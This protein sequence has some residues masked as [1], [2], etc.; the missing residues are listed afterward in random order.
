M[1]LEDF[2]PK[3]NIIKEGK[4][5]ELDQDLKDKKMSDADFKKKYNKSKADVRKEIKPKKKVAEATGDARF[6]KMMGNITG[7]DT[8]SAI[9]AQ[10]SGQIDRQIME[11]THKIFLRL[12][13]FDDPRVYQKFIEFMVKTINNDAGPLDEERHIQPARKGPA[14]DF[15][16]SFDYVKQCI[17]NASIN[18]PPYNTSE[19]RID[20]INEAIRRLELLKS[21]LM[22]DSAI[23]NASRK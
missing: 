15:N 17:T 22:A 23:G 14:V 21:L 12:R 20:R 9:P 19:F 16:K 3:K 2:S 18:V 6:D 5:K 7:S 13:D 4:V 1:K 11:L 10:G 8:P